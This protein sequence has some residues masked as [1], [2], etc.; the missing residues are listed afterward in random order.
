[1]QPLARLDAV[2]GNALTDAQIV[3]L[4]QDT[5]NVEWSAGL[6]LL[7]MNLSVLDNLTDHFDGGSVTRANYATLHGTASLSIATELD[8][9]TA[10][11]RP[12]VT[13]AGIVAGSGLLTARFNL[14]AYLTSSPQTELGENP[15]THEVDGYDIIHVL[16]QP[17]GE[18]FVVA[19]GT[20][21]LAAIET[22]LTT[23]G[24]TKYQ[25]D[26][27]NA[28]L[29][30]ESSKVWPFDDNTTWLNIINDLC[31]AVGY[32]GI[33][34]DWDGLLRVQQ[35]IAPTDRATEW[36]YTSDEATSMLAP[37]RVITRDLFDAPNRWVYYWA[38]DPSE[39]QPVEGAGIYTY[40]NDS[41]GIT[42]VEAR[43]RVISAKPERIDV[44]D[45]SS[46][47]A[48][49]QQRIEADLRLKTVVEVETFPNL[50]SWHFDRVTIADTAL[51]PIADALAVRW[52]LPLSGADQSH[53][54]SLI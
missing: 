7:D 3:A 24:I 51:G 38:K 31:D 30:L 21:Y 37:K 47:V 22:I 41:T 19:D 16:N 53:E 42:S 8:W 29:V 45:Q 10:I 13:I 50:A 35:Y 26:Q 36:L 5:S 27:T 9:G 12:Y 54:W 14:G 28:G 43:G 39:A 48:A 32:Q 4:L 6:E 2:T 15:V 40:V 25:I 34:S 44:A 46:L 52:T 23:Q 11:V 20:G 49:A 1:M 17:V 33:W 18:A